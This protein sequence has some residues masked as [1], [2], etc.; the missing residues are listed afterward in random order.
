MK[1]EFK[2]IS[3]LIKEN[4]KVLD[5]GCGNGELIHYL[6]E[7]KTKYINILCKL[8]RGHLYPSSTTYHMI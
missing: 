7:N 4:S 8:K 5:V 1:K 3:E 6:Q 2:V